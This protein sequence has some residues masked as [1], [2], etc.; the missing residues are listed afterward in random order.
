MANFL[1]NELRRLTDL[2]IEDH[3]KLVRLFYLLAKHEKQEEYFSPYPL[4]TDIFPEEYYTKAV[5]AYDYES[6]LEEIENCN[7]MYKGFWDAK[8][9]NRF[10][11]FSG[12]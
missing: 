1:K 12:N 8:I 9:I 5:Q 7:I 2:D 10:P 4:Q 3:D 6:R 11:V